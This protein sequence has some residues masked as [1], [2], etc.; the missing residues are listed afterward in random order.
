MGRKQGP[1]GIKA[2][3]APHQDDSKDGKLI[4]T[5]CSWITIAGTNLKSDVGVSHLRC[6]IG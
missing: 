4:S 3:A 2:A 1:M 5:F 6:N